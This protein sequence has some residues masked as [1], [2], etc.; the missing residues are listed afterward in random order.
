MS[1]SHSCP[2]FSRMH[3]FFLALL[4]WTM[5]TVIYFHI[6][7]CWNARKMCSN[8]CKN[9]LSID[10]DGGIQVQPAYQAF[11]LAEIH[12]SFPINKSAVKM[13]DEATGKMF[14][15]KYHATQIGFFTRERPDKKLYGKYP[16]TGN[17]LLQMR[18]DAMIGLPGG[19][20]RPGETIKQGLLRELVEEMAVQSTDGIR[21]LLS[22]HNPTN[23]YCG[24]LFAKE[25]T[26]TELR[27][28][29]QRALANPD[30]GLE[31]VGYLFMPT[32]NEVD[33]DPGFDGLPT[34]LAQAIAPGSPPLLVGNTLQQILHVMT[35]ATD[36]PVLPKEYIQIGIDRACTLLAK[37][38]CKP[39]GSM[40]S[41]GATLSNF[42][43]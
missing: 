16:M 34:F 29:G 22:Y 19:G 27:E 10:S 33:D 43:Q 41:T 15:C 6:S 13:K 9:L 42:F 32:L 7:S 23:I 18:H 35:E 11:R 2:M 12:Q 4:M 28:L 38:V 5:F 14:P 20:I 17:L 30:S 40:K 1:V 8:I 36:P 25:V 21:Y 37:T 39:A 26:W 31:N 24:H 3:P